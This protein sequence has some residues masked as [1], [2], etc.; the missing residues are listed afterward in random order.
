MHERT[1]IALLRLAFVCCCALPTIL[2]VLAIVATWT[3]WYHRAQLASIEAEWT[4]RLGL[5]VEID[6][7]ARPAPGALRLIGVRIREPETG[8][9]V[10]R[11]RQIDFADAGQKLALVL[12]QPELQSGQLPFAWRIVH[13][14]FLC[15][16][17]LTVR[18]LRAAA[19][20]LTIHSQTGGVTLRDVQAWVAPE[21]EAVGA[22]IAFVPAGRSEQSPAT[23]HVTRDRSGSQPETRWEMDTGGIPLP[24]SAVAEYLPIVRRLG[25]EAQFD[26]SLTWTL[27]ADGSWSID[28]GGSTFRQVDLSDVFERLPHKLTG[29]ATV[30][31]DRGAIRPGQR[32][33]IFGSLIAIN[34]Y[35]GASLLESVCEHLGLQRP[36]G[37]PPGGAENIAYDLLALHFKFNG[38][39][40]RLWGNCHDQ[41]GY[42]GYPPGVV[43]LGADG[44]PLLQ[45]AEETSDQALSL[46]MALAPSHSE[47]AP[48]S[49]QTA[50]MLNFLL[51]PSRPMDD[52]SPPP[53][54][55]IS[56][57]E[58]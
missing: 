27:A 47:Q 19:L 26:G 11:V 16:P 12:H 20:D 50:L 10:G 41:H 8:A 15:Q 54:P 5:Q 44:R 35:A 2:T 42:G 36:G 48:V 31:L 1:Q 7:F 51:P 6:G 43:M 3:P 57:R 17:N 28:L 49:R 23:I 14:R 33:D 40:L 29:T 52:H 55:R 30:R 13:D 58:R 45:S 24:C 32:V 21:A 39:Q 9:E 18:P 38:P 46:L 25:S 37:A 22:S 56:L 34:G 4:E 53:A